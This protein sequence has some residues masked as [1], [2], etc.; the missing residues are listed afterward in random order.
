MD[1][2][3]GTLSKGVDAADFLRCVG[4]RI[5][6]GNDCFFV[7][8]GNIQALPVPVAEKRLHVF[9]P[10]LIQPVFISGKLGVNLWG[11]AV[12]ELFSQ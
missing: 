5:T 12:A 2:A 1:P 3:F 8:N 9:F 7:G 10:F 4:K 11:I 6:E